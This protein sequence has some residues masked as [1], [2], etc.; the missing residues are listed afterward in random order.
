MTGRIARIYPLLVG[1]EVTEPTGL[2]GAP[3]VRRDLLNENEEWRRARDSLPSIIPIACVETSAALLR[4]VA[5][6]E[7][8]LPCLRTA[9]V[10][11]LMCASVN[12]AGHSTF[13]EGILTHDWCQLTGLPQDT[14][15]Y[16]RKRF[17]ANIRRALDAEA[18]DTY[19]T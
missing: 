11:E 5:D 15:L 14:E 16:I 13:P 19:E 12:T 6:G 2:Y 4:L 8:L 17:A 1:C 9:T 18:K 10:Y 7:E 3:R